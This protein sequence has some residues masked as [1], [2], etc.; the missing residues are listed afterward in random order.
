M[1]KVS[2]KQITLAGIL[3]AICIVMSLTPLG[4]VPVGP[5]KATIL[6]IP[7]II[8]GIFGGYWIGGITGFVFGITSFLQAPTDPTF[9]P[10][11]ASANTLQIILL[12]ITT[13]VPRVLIGIVSSFIY[14]TTEKVSK[15]VSII[16][17]AAIQLLAFLLNL[18]QMIN[19]IKAGES[20][21][22]NLLIA[23]AIIFLN[24]LVARSYNKYNMQVVFATMMGTLTNTILFILMAYQFFK[25]QFVTA[26][27]I[28][29]ET[30]KNIWV[31]AGI[32]NG[33]MELI[34]AVVLINYISLGLFA[35]LKASNG[36]DGPKKQ[37][38][39]GVSE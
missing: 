33:S 24:I 8:A 27:G 13:L 20:Y 2:T 29:L 23:A 9:S 34:L 4:Y 19:N 11:W 37:K 7:V 17:F 21:W 35:Y 18:W 26:F 1:K 16:I 3:S 5:V 30:V 39:T 31:T 6:H 32:T 22:V 12:L 14:K 36:K 25:H 15:K 10:I 38:E 28:S